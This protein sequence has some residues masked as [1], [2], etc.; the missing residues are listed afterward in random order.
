MKTESKGMIFLVSMIVMIGLGCYPSAR[1]LYISQRSLPYTINELNLVSALDFISNEFKNC[2]GECVFTVE[3]YFYYFDTCAISMSG[4][5]RMT[6][7]KGLLKIKLKVPEGSYF[8]EDVGIV[9]VFQHETHQK[10]DFIFSPVIIEESCL[11][12]GGYVRDLLKKENS[13][14]FFRMDVDGLKYLNSVH[15]GGDCYT[16]MCSY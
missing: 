1:N 9:K 16:D 10:P 12:L 4:D 14:F 7:N 2:K 6:S 3:S 5:T 13:I 8:L 15:Y 11:S